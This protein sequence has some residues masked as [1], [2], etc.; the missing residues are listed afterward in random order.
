VDDYAIRPLR[1]GGVVVSRRIELWI[2][3]QRQT[4]IT[5]EWFRL[6][7]KKRED[8]LGNYSKI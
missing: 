4:V 7:L 8:K 6:S 5:N 2:G 3:I 1:F